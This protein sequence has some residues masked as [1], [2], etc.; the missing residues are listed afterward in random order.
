MARSKT[1]REDVQVYIDVLFDLYEETNPDLGKESAVNKT[2]LANYAIETW[3]RLH[4]KLMAWAQNHMVGHSIL[5]ENH[6]FSNWFQ[7]NLGRDVEEDSHELEY[8]GWQ[9]NWLN[10]PEANNDVHKEVSALLDYMIDEELPQ[11]P[12]EP[13][14]DKAMRTLVSELLM[15]RSADNSFW[16]MEL[17]RSLSALNF[18][19]VMPLMRPD[20]KKKQGRAFSL[21]EAKAEAIMQVYFML[22]KGMKKYIALEKVGDGIGQSPET[23]RSWEKSL[24]VDGDFKF[25]FWCAEAAGVYREELLNNHWTKISGAKKLGQMRGVGML[26]YA[27]Y[28]IRDLNKEDLSKIKERIRH[29]R[30]KP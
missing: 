26:E 25:K 29:C 13:L 23:L 21:R 15:S 3:W 30:E 6:E 16:R 18:G 27:S 20:P 1:I 17:Q 24:L 8:I 9:Y 11:G 4:G 2:E 10:M 12:P 5:T 22:G 19:E 7:E 14:T 28:L